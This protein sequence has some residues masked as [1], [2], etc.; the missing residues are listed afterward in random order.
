MLNRDVLLDATRLCG[1]LFSPCLQLAA[2]LAVRGSKTREE[3]G[4]QKLE[5][6]SMPPRP[7]RNLTVCTF[8]P[9]LC[10]TY[11]LILAIIMLNLLIAV[12][13]T[14]HGEVREIG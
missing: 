4:V 7:V 8:V 11:L 5:S 10:Q 1:S 3:Q 13:S 14:A 2:F 12:L 6:N 9:V